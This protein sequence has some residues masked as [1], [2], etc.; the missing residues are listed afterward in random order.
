M[1]PTGSVEGWKRSKI[2]RTRE[3]GGEEVRKELDHVRLVISLL[4]RWL[5]G[6]HQGAVTPKHLQEYLDEFS[7]RFN[8]RLSQNRGKLFYWLMQQAATLS[9]IRVNPRN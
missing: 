4:K 1:P 8:R 6:T 7:L 5:G 3:V 2:L 9:R